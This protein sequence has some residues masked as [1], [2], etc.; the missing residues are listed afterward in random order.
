MQGLDGANAVL[1]GP[2]VLRVLVLADVDAKHQAGRANTAEVVGDSAR[3][4]AVE[5]E[6]IDDCQIIPQAEQTRPR[7]SRLRCRRH[8]SDFGKRKPQR[9][10]GR[11]G[12]SL[13]VEPGP[14]TDRMLKIESPHVLLEA[15]IDWRPC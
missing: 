15:R 5:A 14:Q 1:G 12:G 8:R 7:I 4:G 13:L 6:A 10:P 11:R 2:L 9:R 3:A